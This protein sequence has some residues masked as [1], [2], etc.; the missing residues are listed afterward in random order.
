MTQAERID[1]AEF[2]KRI[3]E[4]V[5]KPLAAGHGD[6]TPTALDTP[7]K[8]ALY[9]NLAKSLDLALKIDETVKRVRLAGLAAW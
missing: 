1:Y 3:A 4:K 2:L 6:D 8:R 5:A 9:S 7:G